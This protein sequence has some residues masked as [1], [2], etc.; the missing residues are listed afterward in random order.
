MKKLR[1]VFMIAV[2]IVATG[3]VSSN[4]ESSSTPEYLVI[5]QP[6]DQAPPAESA[7][8]AIFYYEEGGVTVQQI[9]EFVA[10]TSEPATVTVI[11]LTAQL[12]RLPTPTWQ[13]FRPYGLRPRTG[14]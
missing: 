9:A 14:W 8:P 6:L 5:T 2:A 1:L 3:I 7:V 4:F 13:N 11:A 10:K 12:G